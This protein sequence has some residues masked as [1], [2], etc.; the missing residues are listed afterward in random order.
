MPA[1]SMHGASSVKR[2]HCGRP[3]ISCI[4]ATAHGKA[5][6]VGATVESDVC[7]HAPYLIWASHLEEQLMKTPHEGIPTHL[8]PMINQTRV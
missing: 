7:A 5:R 6:E 8:P 4:E 1:S 3:W 2:E